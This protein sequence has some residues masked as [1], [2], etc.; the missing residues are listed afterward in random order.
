MFLTKRKREQD[1]K[2]EKESIPKVNTSIVLPIRQTA[3]IFKQSVTIVRNHESKPCP[4]VP[5][6]QLEKPKQVNYI[7]VCLFIF[8]NIIYLL[9]GRY[10]L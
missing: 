5:H 4:N 6:G 10:Q 7:S 1:E 2:P 3:S 8:S 9:I